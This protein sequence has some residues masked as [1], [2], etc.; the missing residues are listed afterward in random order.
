MDYREEIES[1]A[2]QLSFGAKING[3]DY[4]KIV[5]A[6][7]GGSGIAGKIFQELYT[8]KPVLTVEDYNIPEFVDKH[9]LFIGMSY[10]GNTEETLSAVSLAKKKGARIATI[11]SGGRISDL[12]EENITIPKVGMQPRAAIGY[13]LVPLLLSFGLSSKAE[14]ARAKKLVESLDSSNSECEHHAKELLKNSKIPVIYGV[15][16]FKTIAYR[17]KTQMSENAKVIAYANSFPELNHNDTMA[18]AETSRKGLFYFF[19]FESDDAKM[20]KRIELTSRVTD[21]QFHMI[22]P[23]GES[24]TEKLFYLI[25]YGD[26]ISYHLGRLRGLDTRDIGLV[27]DIKRG[28]SKAYVG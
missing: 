7:M 28:L 3:I 1:L 20:N 16:P 22:K 25:H 13:L 14:L 26:Y 10:S 19:V 11:S 9:T 4:D 17:W 8:K 5:I 6:G 24:V 27:E 2:D 21:T 18:L 15:T 23:K 12:G